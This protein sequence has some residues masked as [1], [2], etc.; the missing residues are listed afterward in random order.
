MKLSEFQQELQRLHIDAALFLTNEQKRDLAIEYLTQTR[1]DFGALIVPATSEPSLIIPG[2]EYHRIKRIAPVNVVQANP[3]TDIIKKAVGK[4][5]TLGINEQMLTVAEQQQLNKL[6]D[7][8][9]IPISEIVNELRLTKTNKELKLLQEAADIGCEIVN[10]CIE[11]FTRFKTE[12]EAATFLR[13]KTAGAGCDLSFPPIVASGP[14]GATPHHI[15]TG[16]MH[17]GFVVIDFGV[18]HKGYCSD[19]TRTIY[20]GKP[21]Q[22]EK[23]VYELLL[24]AQSWGVKQVKP[25][26]NVIGLQNAVTKKLGQYGKYF[27]HRL[28][29]S[30]GMEV[31]DIMTAA[32]IAKPVLQQGML[33]TIE[34]GIYIPNKFGMRIEDTVAVTKRGCEVLTRKTSKDLFTA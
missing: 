15:P 34:P 23:K 33:W 7:A 26:V 30:V 21:S 17:K 31:H 19:M 27:I 5:K 22:Q 14:N 24:S 18:R 11:R 32:M 3:I 12:Q 6:L 2:Y 29:H 8:K 9:H 1:V 25:G 16:K 4:A 13:A 28:G 20:L 10:S